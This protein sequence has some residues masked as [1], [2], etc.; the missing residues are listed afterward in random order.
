MQ[1]ETGRGNGTA[2]GRTGRVLQGIGIIATALQE[3]GG[4]KDTFRYLRNQETAG[5]IFEA[6]KREDLATSGIRWFIE[7]AFGKG[8]R[9][10]QMVIVAA[11]LYL[12]NL[13]A[14]HSV[15]CR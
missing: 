10:I 13:F 8:E 12:G 2:H 5:N 4:H 14:C 9:D 7:G 6:G 15:S 3:R 1:Q 11:L